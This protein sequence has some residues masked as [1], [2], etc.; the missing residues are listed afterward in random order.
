MTIGSYYAASS[1]AVEAVEL[2]VCV[3]Y[4]LLVVQT[5]VNFYG[6]EFLLARYS[7]PLIF[8]LRK[9]TISYDIVVDDI[10]VAGW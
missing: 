10:V 2:S 6:S 3:S 4:Y 5:E 7:L 1:F 8:H 9:H